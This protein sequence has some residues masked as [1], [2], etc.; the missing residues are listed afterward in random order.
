ME[1]TENTDESEGRDRLTINLQ[2]SVSSVLSVF[3]VTKLLRPQTQPR[4]LPGSRR[5]P[6]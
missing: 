3:S 2:V 6:G 1:N 4:V 5:S